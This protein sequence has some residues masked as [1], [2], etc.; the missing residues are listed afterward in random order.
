MFSAHKFQEPSLFNPVP[1]ARPLSDNTLV[2]SWQNYS[3]FT[4]VV[5]C[6]TLSGA[7][8][9]QASIMLFSGETHTPFAC[10]A[11]IAGGRQLPVRHPRHLPLDDFPWALFHRQILFIDVYD[12][13]K[14]GQVIFV[15]LPRTWGIVQIALAGRCQWWSGQHDRQGW[16]TGGGLATL[17]I[18]VFAISWSCAG[19]TTQW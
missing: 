9:L 2:T 14:V 10:T 8:A 5:D 7:G 13:R 19:L 11:L 3:S 4:L 18:S 15:P 16:E 12:V 1:G 17:Y 6:I